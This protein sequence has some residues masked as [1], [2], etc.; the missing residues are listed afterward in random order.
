[1]RIE[2]IGISGVGKTYTAK[3]LFPK[4]LQQYPDMM[5]P[6][7]NLYSHYSWFV[8]NALKLF[9][10][11]IYALAHLKWV[12]R[13]K[14][15]IGSIVKG[16]YIQRLVLLFNGTFLKYALE[17]NNNRASLFDEGLAQYIWAL[18]LRSKTMPEVGEVENLVGL[19][20]APDVLYVV[21]ASPS[22]IAKRIVS[23]GRRVYIQN[24]EEME[25]VIAQMQ[26]IQKAVVDL[27]VV[28][29]QGMKSFTIDNEC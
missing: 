3:K 15:E 12:L 26:E 10:S 8:R 23:R 9:H 13:L 25:K 5:W 14:K 4:L 19:F 27:L 7:N 24:S 18:H 29:C 1:M 28:C 22:T 11:S 2:F 16:D 20:G 21:K 17:V 6:L